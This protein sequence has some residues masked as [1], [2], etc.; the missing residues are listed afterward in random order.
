V[1]Y[2]W[3][4]TCSKEVA[5]LYN[6]ANLDA[7]LPTNDSGVSFETVVIPIALYVYH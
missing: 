1:K 4:K 3:Y 5:I 6:V 2:F 7:P